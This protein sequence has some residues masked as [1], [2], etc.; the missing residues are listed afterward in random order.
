MCTGM[1]QCGPEVVQVRIRMGAI[2]KSKK[3]MQVTVC[4]VWA[5]MQPREKCS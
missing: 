5:D 2:T 3:G 4:K 1:T